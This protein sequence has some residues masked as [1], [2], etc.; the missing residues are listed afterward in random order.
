MRFKSVHYGVY[1]KNQIQTQKS[2]RQI[3]QKHQDRAFCTLRMYISIK[4]K[5]AEQKQ[6]L[7]FFR[8]NQI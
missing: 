4:L 6:T 3:F 8:F 2:Q 5:G 7:Y 1:F